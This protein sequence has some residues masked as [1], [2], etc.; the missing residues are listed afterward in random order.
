MIITLI[1]ESSQAHLTGS[2]N[3]DIQ[4]YAWNRH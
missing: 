1:E 4:P 2:G 3:G